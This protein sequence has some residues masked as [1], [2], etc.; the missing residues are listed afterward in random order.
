MSQSFR[1]LPPAL[2]LGVL[3]TAPTAQAAGWVVWA[4]GSNNVQSRG[5][6]QIAISTQR[7][8]FL[9]HLVPQPDASGVVFRAQLDDAAP[10]FV[11]MPGFPLPTP[12][13]GKTYNNV[14][15]M[16]T[17]VQ[18]E[19]IVGLSANG[20]SSNTEPM[21]M[22]WDEQAGQWFAPKINP[23]NEVC[24]H[25]MYIIDRAPNGDIWAGC[26][27][28]GAYHSIDDGATFDYVDISKLVGASTPGYYPTRA[29]GA[30]DLGALYGLHIGPDDRIYFGT[31]T[32]GVVYSTDRGKSFLP[33]DAAPNDPMSSMAR[34]TN[35]GNVGGL[36]VTPD[37][38]ILVQ[39]NV[40]VAPYP[41]PDAT[42][43]YV[44]DTVAR[45]TTLGT[46]FPDYFLGGQTVTQI[47]TMPSGQ[48]FLHSNHPTVDPMTGTPTPGGIMASDDGVA[49]SEFN[50]GIDEVF[51]VPNMNVWVDGNGPR[52]GRAF[53]V[54]GD[55]LYTVTETGRIYVL[56][57]EPMGGTDGG[58]AGNTTEDSA[59]TTDSNTTANPTTGAT[60]GSSG[61]AGSDS[62]APTGG[63]T[64]GGSGSDGSDGVTGEASGTAAGSSGTTADS[65][66]GG[67]DG[68]ACRSDD[69]PDAGGAALLL[70][71][72]GACTRLR[73][74]RAAP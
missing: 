36:G 61:D 27:W 62:G 20:S 60:G 7:E 13:A 23:P 9:T 54:D 39:G 16:T 35:S 5:F 11:Q 58:T 67:A 14:F 52:L 21:L 42:K 44:F 17:N 28:H 64:G 26:Q 38:R 65:E 15:C 47:V 73:R 37:G 43:F 25:N 71:S 55:D 32:G 63:G 8:I 45:T 69:T 6:P 53:A 24:A 31:E 10:Q 59:T 48:M 70:L 50:E 34:A 41:D 68:C 2:C 12:A 22:T 74:R 19:P 33:L 3:L 29:T 56:T 30:G 4:D 18:G 49:W 66:T 51:M 72:V 46:G 57:T 1:N 40:G